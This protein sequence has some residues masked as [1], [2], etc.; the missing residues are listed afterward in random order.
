MRGKVSGHTLTESHAHTESR[1]SVVV[2]RPGAG[3]AVVQRPGAGEIMHLLSGR[4]RSTG[5][6]QQS[7]ESTLPLCMKGRQ[8]NIQKR[9]KRS[10]SK[11]HHFR[12]SVGAADSNRRRQQPPTRC[13]HLPKED[14]KSNGSS[15]FRPGG[16]IPGPGDYH[17]P[18]PLV[19][20]TAR[21]QITRPS[22]FCNDR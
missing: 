16:V 8:T 21:A 7:G 5:Q 12:P 10:C 14:C 3:S 19:Y 11:E 17:T 15:S 9:P 13:G 20:H 4:G 2:Q 18:C 22:P 1:R 6:G